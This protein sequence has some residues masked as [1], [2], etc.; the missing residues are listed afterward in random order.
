MTRACIKSGT[1]HSLLL[2]TSAIKDFSHDAT[3]IQI[4]KL[5][6]LLSFYFHEALQ[7]LKSFIYTNFWFHRVFRFAIED[8][9]ISRFLHAYVTCHLA[10][11]RESSNVGYKR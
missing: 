1:N 7:L 8:T 5:P 11:G 9:W 3:K 10:G 4:K 6:I 2:T